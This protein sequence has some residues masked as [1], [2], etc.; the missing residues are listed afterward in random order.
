MFEL[1][2]A[3]P[4]VGAVAAD[5]ELAGVRRVHLAATHHYLYYRVDEIK[6][7]IEVLALW[8]TSRGEGPGF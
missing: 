8:S 4:E 6:L 1:I 2:A 3:H 7:R 5:S